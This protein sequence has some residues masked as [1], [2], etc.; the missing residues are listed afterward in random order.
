MHPTSDSRKQKHHVLVSGVKTLGMTFSGCTG[1]WRL[2]SL[3]VED[4]IVKRLYR[5]RGENP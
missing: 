4:I 2:P 3:L 5:L 1:Q